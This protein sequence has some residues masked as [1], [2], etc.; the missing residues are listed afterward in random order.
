MYFPT[1][2]GEC[3]TAAAT[4][5]EQEH[6][7]PMHPSIPSLILPFPGHFENREFSYHFMKPPEILYSQRAKFYIIYIL[8]NFYHGFP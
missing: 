3:G 1:R 2:V 4:L 6:T 8:S 7:D 5:T